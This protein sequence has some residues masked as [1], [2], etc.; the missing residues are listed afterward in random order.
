[1]QLIYDW[2]DYVLKGGP[3]PAMLKDRIN[4]EVMGAQRLAPRPIHREDGGPEPE[5]LSGE[6]DRGVPIHLVGP[7]TDCARLRLANN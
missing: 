4:Y 7:Q 5:A 3:K 1:M 2:L 6:H